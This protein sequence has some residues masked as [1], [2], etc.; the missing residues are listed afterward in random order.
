MNYPTFNSKYGT[1]PPPVEPQAPIEV[2]IEQ[3]LSTNIPNPWSGLG[4]EPEMQPAQQLSHWGEY[5]GK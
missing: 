1:P 2:P 3:Q 5:T 4:N